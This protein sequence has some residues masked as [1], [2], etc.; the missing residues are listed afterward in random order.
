MV[1][2]I[3][4]STQVVFLFN[5]AAEGIWLLFEEVCKEKDIDANIFLIYLMELKSHIL[6][7]SL[8]I[9]MIILRKG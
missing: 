3:Q 2:K 8:I 9:M 4:L 7:V 5:K 6:S 1:L